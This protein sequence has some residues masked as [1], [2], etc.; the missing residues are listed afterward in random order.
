MHTTAC[1]AKKKSLRLIAPRIARFSPEI[2]PN[3]Y[4]FFALIKIAFPREYGVQSS[5]QS[6]DRFSKMGYNPPNT[7]WGTIRPTITNG[8]KTFLNPKNI[9]RFGI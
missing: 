8:N 2:H 4:V 9:I 7:T 5:Q 6:N 1:D 3:I